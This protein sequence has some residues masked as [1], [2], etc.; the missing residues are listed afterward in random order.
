MRRTLYLFIFVLFFPLYLTA[1]RAE[2]VPFT[3]SYKGQ[4]LTKNFVT[5]EYWLKKSDTTTY[6]PINNLLDF[7]GSEKNEVVV[8]FSQLQWDDRIGEEHKEA[9]QLLITNKKKALRRGLVAIGPTNLPLS[10]DNNRVGA[11]F[12]A[13]DNTPGLLYFE[14]EVIATDPKVERLLKNEP[15]KTQRSYAINGIVEKKT[16]SSGNSGAKGNTNKVNAKRLAA[17]LKQQ[18]RES[19]QYAA[20]IQLLKRY[21]PLA[22]EIKK[23][24]PQAYTVI[25]K[26]TLEPHL[27][28]DN[29]EHQDYFKIEDKNLLDRHFF[30]IKVLKSEV[31]SLTVLDEWGKRAIIKL[32]NILNVQ[33]KVVEEEEQQSFDFTITGGRPPYE[34]NWIK[35]GNPYSSFDIEDIQDGNIKITKKELLNKGLEGNFQ[36]QAKDA[37]L[38]IATV[39]EVLA[40]QSPNK[41]SSLFWL[42]LALIL[43]LVVWGW[44]YL[45]YIRTQSLLKE[46][47]PQEADEI[48]KT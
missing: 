11:K 10:K 46:I 5:V 25:L 22:Y 18:D 1:Q 9:L 6:F 45:K 28:W 48:V 2:T 26:N 19:K 12:K 8:N 32:D 20:T 14:I 16:T 36:V 13:K 38:Q 3:F 34:I 23:R 35:K 7:R 40:L 47:P 21:S 44:A 43:G 37:L 41:V 24:N 27:D 29:M 15:N 42:F 31:F 17:E 30:D 33:M 4:K 39:P